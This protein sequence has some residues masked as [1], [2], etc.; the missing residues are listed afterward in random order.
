M[1]QIHSPLR[2]A[3]VLGLA[4]LAAAPAA[5]Q[6]AIVFGSETTLIGEADPITGSQT[7]IGACGGSVQAIA[8]DTAQM[9]VSTTTGAL[10]RKTLSEPFVAF[11]QQAESDATALAAVAGS[12]LVGGSDGTLRMYAYDQPGS[13]LVATLPFA[14]EA[15]TVHEWTAYVAGPFG[16]L[17]QGD[18]FGGNFQPLPVC[19]GSITA[20]VGFS[21]HPE[22]LLYVATGDGSLWTFDINA[23]NFTNFI[24][25]PEPAT[26]LGVFGEDLVVGSADG[27]ARRIDRQTGGVKQTYDA[28]VSIDALGMAKQQSSSMVQSFCEGSAC[29]CG[30]DDLD[31]ACINSTGFGAGTLSTGTTSVTLDDLSLVAID[32]PPNTLARYYMGQPMGTFPFGAGVICVGS[33]GYST[34]RFPVA[35][36][37]PHG[38]L[39]LG[40]GIAE[41]ANTSFG[42][43]DLIAPGTFWAFQGWY[44]DPSGPCGATVNTTEAMGVM[45]V[46]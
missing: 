42:V 2:G 36:T 18:P 8:V 45:F 7:V 41:L 22:K 25:L 29:P 34:F 1:R 12:V 14:V 24:S 30:N 23:N 38:V 19:T 31:H 32:L 17:F 46:Q 44:R 28:G 33:G 26:G 3:A 35:N 21:K 9:T 37:G 40:P 43:P 10:Y 39:Q 16:Q 27:I 11:W 13:M 15:L 20:M 5:A 4:A 6:Q